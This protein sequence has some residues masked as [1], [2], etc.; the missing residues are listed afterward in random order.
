[1]N[2]RS[3]QFERFPT[4]HWSLVARAGVDDAQA[5]RQALERL[6][7][8]Y[9]PALRTHLEFNRRHP[10]ADADDLVQQFV[11]DKIL[12]R[13]LIAHA[14]HR[15]GRFRTFLLT[16]LDRFVLNQLRDRQAKRRAPNEGRLVDVY[17]HADAVVGQP[18]NDAFDVAW[19]QSLLDGA[20]QL[21]QTQ[22]RTTGRETVW[23]VFRLR[24]IDPLL[25]DAPP[26]DYP[27]L[28]ERFG[29]QSPSQAA[30]LLVTGK[31]MFTRCLRDAVGQYACDA[32]QIEAEIAELCQ[33]LARCRE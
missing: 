31:R 16:S 29:L 12:Q 22:C 25:H 10:P 11:A 17:E 18:A 33:T 27:E 1:M 23:E 8:Q 6:L 4:T 7:T 5:K 26:I 2:D 9:V 24:L 21:M 14:D 28:V 30:N 20:L 15:R 13:D 19:A 32:E 3:R